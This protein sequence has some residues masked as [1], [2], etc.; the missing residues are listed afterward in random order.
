VK[1]KYRDGLKKAGL[2]IVLLCL[3]AMV[4]LPTVFMFL[5]SFKSLDEI[6][7]Y[8]PKLFPSA[9]YFQ[10]YADAWAA[11]PFG[12]FLY[13][14]V[15]VGAL[16]T[17][18][19]IVVAVLAAFAFSHIKPWGSKIIFLIFLSGMMIPPQVTI[20]PRYFIMQGIGWIS[21]YPALIVPFLARP[22]GIFLLYQFFRT[23]PK[24]LEEAAKLDGCGP[25]RFLVLILM[26]LSRASIGALAILSFVHSWNRYMWPL[27]ITNSTQMQTAPIGIRMF[28]SQTEGTYLGMM[29][30][31]SVIVIFPAI[32]AFILGQKQFVRAL[33]RGGI[34]G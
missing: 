32:V 7:A 14:S 34:K 22:I 9:L 13:N 27:V 19:A 23:L 11:A 26:P 8:P 12:I 10:N 28:I 1:K 3:S 31:G 30:A 15:L 20:I 4:L 33:A 18:G 17:F 21:T 24:E 6:F 16:T 2:H 29:M 25:F 5:G